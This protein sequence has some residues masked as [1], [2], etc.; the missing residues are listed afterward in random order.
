M[1]EEGETMK[2]FYCL[3]CHKELGFLAMLLHKL[4]QHYIAIETSN[5]YY[6]EI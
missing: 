4:R 3:N 6:E 5:N 1:S 2:R